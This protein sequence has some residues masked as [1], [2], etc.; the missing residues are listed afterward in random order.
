MGRRQNGME[1][2][3]QRAQ[4]VNTLK[5]YGISDK[6]LDAM[7]RVPRH[8][9]IPEVHRNSSYVDTPLIIG[10]AQTIS[11]P[12]MVAIMCN[13][14]ELEKGLKVLEIGAGSGYNAAIMAELVGSKGRIFSVERLEPLARFARDNLE[15]TGYKNVE[16]ILADGT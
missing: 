12:H 5:G 2:A 9:F 6:V 1:Y 13:L 16:V 10:Y 7:R 15:R 3:R 14:L 8:L 4:L 11:A